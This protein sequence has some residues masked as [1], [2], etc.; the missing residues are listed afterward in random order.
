VLRILLVTA[1]RPPAALVCGEPSRVRYVSPAVGPAVPVGPLWFVVPP[2]ELELLPD[3]PALVSP[4]KVLIYVQ[5]PLRAPI[6]L[7]G[8]SQRALLGVDVERPSSQAN[9]GGEAS[10]VLDHAQDA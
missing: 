4:T 5:R 10:S 7:R 1:G 8:R 6:R 9:D 2:P 3:Y